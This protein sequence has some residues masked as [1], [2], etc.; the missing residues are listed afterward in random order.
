M[1]LLERREKPI[2]GP[3]DR[4]RQVIQVTARRV[5]RAIRLAIS[6]ILVASIGSMK[7]LASRSPEHK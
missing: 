6:T 4:Y 1:Q 2:V 5:L 3:I 7:C